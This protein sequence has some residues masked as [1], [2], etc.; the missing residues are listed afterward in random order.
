MLVC[1]IAAAPSMPAA[2]SAETK[3]FFVNIFYS[4]EK[5]SG[6]LQR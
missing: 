2:N 3:T 5:P 4:P 1:G 6:M